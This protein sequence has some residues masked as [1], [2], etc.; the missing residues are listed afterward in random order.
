MKRGFRADDPA[1]TDDRSGADELRVWCADDEQVAL[2][3][4]A[5]QVWIIALMQEQTELMEMQGAEPEGC[6]DS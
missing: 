4:E 6:Q 5:E 1:G 3:A 2:I